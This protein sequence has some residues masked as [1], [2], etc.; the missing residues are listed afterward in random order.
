MTNRLGIKQL[1]ITGILAALVF[2]GTYVTRIELP[3]LGGR[4][5]FHLGNMF[6][7]VA[8]LLFGKKCGAFAGAIGMSFF[9]VV[10]GSFIAY[11]PFTFVLKFIV[12]F[13]CGLIK[14]KN[15]YK[16]NSAKL[17][18]LAVFIALFINVIFSPIISVFIKTV[19]YGLNFYVAV[20]ATL[21]SIVSVIV[22]AVLSG[23]LAIVILNLLE[24]R[25]FFDEV[26]KDD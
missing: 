6:C 12:G 14:E 9:D 19:I 13:I 23:V 17:N 11:F 5:I 15:K 21:G 4:T 25:K 16:L 22:N 20:V 8:A 3:I 18:L 2:L 10:S 24:K 7:L 26:I 1:I